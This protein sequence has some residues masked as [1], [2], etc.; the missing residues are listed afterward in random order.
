MQPSPAT[1]SRM[2]NAVTSAPNALELEGLTK[3]FKVGRS[4]K[5]VTAVNNVT[6]NIARG[7]STLR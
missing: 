5:S 2:P 1:D 3:V 4:G 7:E 6:L